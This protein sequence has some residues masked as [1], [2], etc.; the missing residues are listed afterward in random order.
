MKVR[1]VLFD[2]DGTPRGGLSCW[3]SSGIIFFGDV[4]EVAVVIAAISN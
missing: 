1:L 3:S 2:I 4:L